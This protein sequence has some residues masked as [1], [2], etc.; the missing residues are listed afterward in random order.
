VDPEK[1]SKRYSDQ[2]RAEKELDDELAKSIKV[3]PGDHKNHL[4]IDRRMNM[5]RSYWG[6]CCSKT[7]HDLVNFS[8]N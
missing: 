6:Q 4:V 3:I 5:F 1:E 8:S 7:I 2:L